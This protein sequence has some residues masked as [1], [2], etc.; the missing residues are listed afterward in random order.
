MTPPSERKLDVCLLDAKVLVAMGDLHEAEPEVA[1]CLEEVPDDLTALNL[2]AK[3][4]HMKGELSQA[5]ACWAQLH[6]R[7]P[8]NELALMCLASILQMA[9][10]PERH[11][12]DFLALGQPPLARRP[13]VQ[14]ELADAFRQLL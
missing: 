8:H 5:V 10:D 4:K 9:K 12:A 11:A 2:F 7:S 13:T 3:I 14:I 1:E 6:A